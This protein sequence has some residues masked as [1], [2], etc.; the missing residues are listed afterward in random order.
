MRQRCPLTSRRDQRNRKKSLIP[1]NCISSSSLPCFC[2][3][4]GK[5]CPKS[6]SLSLVHIFISCTRPSLA[7]SMVQ[8]QAPWPLS[9]LSSSWVLDSLDSVEHSNLKHFLILVSVT[10]N[11]SDFHPTSLGPSSHLLPFCTTC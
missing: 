10:L 8:C 6:K 7:R 5:I 1:G 9:Y 4:P 3:P 2:L 11:S